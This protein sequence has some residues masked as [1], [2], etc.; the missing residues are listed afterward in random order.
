MEEKIY[1]IN[2]TTGKVGT[3]IP[4]SVTK[5][6]IEGTDKVEWS[7]CFEGNKKMQK[8]KIDYYFNEQEWIEDI[9]RL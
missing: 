9:K 5:K 2:R 4:L 6:P 3:I 1:F 8:D 7:I